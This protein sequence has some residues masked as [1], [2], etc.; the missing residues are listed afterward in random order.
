MAII[1]KICTHHYGGRANDIYAPTA[2]TSVSQINNAHA[3]RTFNLSSMGWYVGYSF[4]IFKDGTVQQFRALGE[5]T[6]GAT[7][8]NFDTIHIALAGNFITRPDGMVVEKPTSEQT[9]SLK[10]LI[11]NLLREPQR[12]TVAPNTT[13]DLSATRIYPHRILQ[14]NH[15]QCDCLPDNWARNLITEVTDPRILLL[16]QLLQTYRTLYDL[17]YKRKFGKIVGGT[18]KSCAGLL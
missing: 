17:L 5:Q 4:I 7:G 10:T 8:S 16:Q 9:S 13:F 3:A 1:S 6:A 15:T 11:M 2:D 12:Y 18:D 14:P